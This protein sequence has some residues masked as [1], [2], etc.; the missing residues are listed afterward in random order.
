MFSHGLGGLRTVYSS[1][2]GEFTSYGFVVCAIEHRDGTA[3][4]TFVNHPTKGNGSR[5]EREAT[6]HVDHLQHELKHRWDVID[7]IF[8]KETDMIPDQTMKTEWTRNFELPK[9]TC[10]SLNLKKRLTL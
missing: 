2:C 8:P 10:V 4:R 3:S 1:L 9:L 5:K 7:F 6:G